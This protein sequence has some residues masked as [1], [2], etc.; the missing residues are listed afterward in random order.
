[1][2]R[3]QASKTTQKIDREVLLKGWVQTR[4]NHGKLVFLDLRDATG[5]VQVVVNPTVSQQ[6]FNVA[7]ELGNEYVIAVQG[8]VNQRPE[9]LVNPNLA[10]GT[11][12]VEAHKLQIIRVAK[13][14]PFPIE[15]DG[16]EINEELRLKYRYLDL[17]RE[18]L[19]KTFSSVTRSSST[20]VIFWTRKNSLRSKL[21][22]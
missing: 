9:N 10:T 6:A 15:G 8:Q 18:R 3:T 13:E 11:V 20:F 12:E 16:Y 5:V 1:M 19:K 21:R 4:R 7:Q 17:R 14:P 2:L 22:F